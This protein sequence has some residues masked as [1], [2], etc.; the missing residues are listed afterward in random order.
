MSK[1]PP[2]KIKNL[3]NK[4]KEDIFILFKQINTVID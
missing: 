2:P 3:K 4:K 1:H